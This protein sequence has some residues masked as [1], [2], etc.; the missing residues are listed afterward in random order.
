[1]RL[2]PTETDRLL[3]HTAADVARRRL[4][5][6]LLLNVPEATALIAAAVIEAARD[7]LRLA[8]AIAAGRTV[9]A[10]TNVLPGVSDVV[11]EVSVEAVFDDGT[12]LAVVRDP[13]RAL[14]AGHGLGADAPGAVVVAIDTSVDDRPVTEVD[15]QNTAEVPVSIT[16]HFHFFEINPRMRFDRAAGYGKHLAIPAGSVVRFEPGQTLRV[17]LVPI[18]GNRIVI[19]FAGLVDGPLDAPGALQLAL[20]RAAAFGYLDSGAQ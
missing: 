6:G 4:E 5:R 13:F 9:L 3:I 19:G 10:A 12:R 1:M 8:E 20:Q 11:I 16:S 17:S 7:G 14:E 2:T 15:V 18:G